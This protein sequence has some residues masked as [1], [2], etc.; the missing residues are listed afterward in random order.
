[1]KITGSFVVKVNLEASI[2]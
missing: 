1:M 2:M